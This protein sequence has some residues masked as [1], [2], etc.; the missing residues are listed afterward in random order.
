[1]THRLMAAPVL[2]VVAFAALVATASG[3][4][5][6]TLTG[7]VTDRACGLDHHGR[8]VQ[9]CVRSCAE[10]SGEYALVVATKSATRVYTLVAEDDVK[11]KLYDFAGE[12]V[13]VTGVREAGDVVTVTA[14]KSAK[15]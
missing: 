13:V 6:V 8:D 4:D 11:A 14:V 9:Q 1:M 3:A 7:T 5:S 12:S 2:V 10:E 15:P